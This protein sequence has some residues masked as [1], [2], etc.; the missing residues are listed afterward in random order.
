[1]LG[2]ANTVF[3]QPT[4]QMS[5]QNTKSRKAG[6]IKINHKMKLTVEYVLCLQTRYQQLSALSFETLPQLDSPN[7]KKSSVTFIKQIN[8]VYL[9][10]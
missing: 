5:N 7:S 2:L 6:K 1:M 10:L 8:I 3:D 4:N 9:I